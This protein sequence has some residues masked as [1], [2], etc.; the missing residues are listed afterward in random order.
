MKFIFIFFN[1]ILSTLFAQEK[2]IRKI[3]L[4]DAQTEALRHNFTVRQA[5]QDIIAAKRRIAQGIGQGLLTIDGQASYTRN[6]NLA[7]TQITIS[8]SITQEVE[9]GTKNAFSAGL[10]AHLPLFDATYIVG[11]QSAIAYKALV[12][13]QKKNTNYNVIDAVTQAY[14]AVIAADKNLYFLRE[15]EK[16]TNKIVSDMTEMYRVGYIEET[17]LD[18][19]KVNQVKVENNIFALEQQKEISEK[20]LKY[21][22]GISLDIPILLFNCKCTLQLNFITIVASLFFSFFVESC[23]NSARLCFV[24][25]SVRAH[26]KFE[27][28]LYTQKFILQ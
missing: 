19:V 22:M 11:L 16:N 8:D 7:V 13:M 12:N 9:L 10:S 21:Q 5:D 6:L 18:Q 4:I 20:M 15:S 28:V 26:V 24:S 1:I 3:S 25:C 2:E 14:Y 27:T 23:L 17:D